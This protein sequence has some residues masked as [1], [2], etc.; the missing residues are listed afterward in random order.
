MYQGEVIVNNYDT[1]LVSGMYKLNE[2]CYLTT[3][4]RDI[5]Y[6][7]GALK[8]M[9]MWRT[10]SNSQYLLQPSI[11]LQAVR[12]WLE[13]N[14]ICLFTES[15]CSPA[16]LRVP[17]YSTELAPV[18]FVWK[19]LCQMHAST[20]SHLIVCWWINLQIHNSNCSYLLSAVIFL[21]RNCRHLHLKEWLPD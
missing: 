11:L 2:V 10:L 14:W 5:Y 1:S 17:I 3:S 19:V 15:H 6:F 18:I 16:F 20:C 21:E 4:I 8:A 9:R 13:K 12:D 7:T